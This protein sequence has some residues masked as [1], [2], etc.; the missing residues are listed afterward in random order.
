MHTNPLT[1][2][3][4][5]HLTLALPRALSLTLSLY[6]TALGLQLHLFP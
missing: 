1:G 4:H 5:V 3:L 2:P 6:Q